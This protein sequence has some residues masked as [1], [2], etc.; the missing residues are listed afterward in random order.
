VTPAGIYAFEFH[1]PYFALR[2]RSQVTPR[3]YAQRRTGNFAFSKSDS[4]EENE[5]F[6]EAQISVILMGIDEWVWTLI[7]LVDTYFK[8]DEDIKSD[9]SSERDAP[10]G[11]G[12]RYALP[13]WNPREYFLLVLSRRI[14]Q[15]TMEWGNIVLTLEKRLDLWVRDLGYLHCPRTYIN[16][17]KESDT[18]LKALPDKAFVDD[19]GLSQ[20][21]KYTLAIQILRLFTNLLVKTIDSWDTFATE[22]LSAFRTTSD[23]E[24]RP[25]KISTHITKIESNVS[26]LRFL[27]QTLEQ[28]IETFESRRSNV[29]SSLLYAKMD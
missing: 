2:K 25:T 29:C 1:I 24:R 19:E 23:P 9:R 4:D 28:R 18:F 6:H 3:N 20:T 26:E 27:R 8:S 7:C 13:V 10:S 11:G 12:S 22:Q 21:K 5:Y 16:I 17:I 14:A 15:V